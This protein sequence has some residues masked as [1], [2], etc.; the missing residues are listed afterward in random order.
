MSS[1]AS[2]SSSSSPSACARRGRRRRRPHARHADDAAPAEGPAG[3]A[4]GAERACRRRR[5]RRSSAAFKDWPHGSIDDDAAAR[6][7]E[8]SERTRGR[9]VLPRASRCS[10]P[11]TRATRRPR[12]SA[13]KKLGRDTIIQGRADNL[14]HPSS[15][16]RRRAPSYPI[17]VPLAA[18]PAARA[19][20]AAAGAGPPDLGRAPLPAGGAGRARATSRRTSPPRSASSTR[21]T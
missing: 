3:Q 8:Y 15:S 13:A 21:T 18:E 9:A 10:G 4:A 2:R 5:A 17:F 14:L 1:R 20:L 19:G 11:A 6:A 7:R 12:S 16:S